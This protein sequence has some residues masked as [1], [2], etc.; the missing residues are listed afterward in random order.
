MY[1]LRTF[2][3]AEK[4]RG[5]SMMVYEIGHSKTYGS[6]RMYKIYLG[7]DLVA[8]CTSGVTD[9]TYARENLNL[10]HD[11]IEHNGCRHR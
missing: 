1:L 7:L 5:Y 8:N 11:S 3:S 9:D 10:D 2:E 6:I 4:I